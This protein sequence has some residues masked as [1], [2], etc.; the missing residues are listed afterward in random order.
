MSGEIREKY[1]KYGG[2]TGEIREREQTGSYTS[3]LLTAEPKVFHTQS[4][5]VV[6][7]N[8]DPR[9]QQR[10]MES[11]TSHRKS[12]GKGAKGHRNC[13]PSS[14]KVRKIFV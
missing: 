9:H 4:L 10:T 3:F 8:L 11:C 2:N 12:S 13:W 14:S 6:T 5:S 1:R 7:S